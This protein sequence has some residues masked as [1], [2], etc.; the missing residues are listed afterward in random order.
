VGPEEESA[1]TRGFTTFGDSERRWDVAVR[2]GATLS[3]RGE[4]VRADTDE[5]GREVGRRT[6]D[7]LKLADGAGREK[8]RA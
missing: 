7:R 4:Y 8:L 6:L 1:I 2:R 5:D 3:R